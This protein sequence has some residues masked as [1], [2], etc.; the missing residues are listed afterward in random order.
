M[1]DRELDFLSFGEVLVDFFP[2][3]PGRPLS[4]VPRFTRHVGGA[5]ANVAVALARLGRRSGMHTLVGR[6]DFGVFLRSAL[7]GEGVDV[8]GV[9]THPSARTG[10]TF[11]S[12]GPKGERS[13]LFYRH[14]SA[15]QMI[16]PTDVD[17]A[18]IGK[19]R[20]FHFGSST[21]S[22]EPARSA[23]LA[24][25]DAARAAGCVV[26]C[27][28]NVR[29]HLWEE[30]GAPR[31]WLEHVMPQVHVLKVAEDELLATC[32]MSDPARAAALLRD[33]GAQ[34][35]VVTRADKG[36]IYDGAEAGTGSVACASVPVVDTTGAGDGFVAG[37]WTA[38][39]E[40]GSLALT[41][42]AVDAACLFGHRV[43][44]RVVGAL[45]ATAAL[46]RRAGLVP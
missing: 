10:I 46:P 22:R 13:F 35:V 19:A 8:R 4:E 32:A 33:W 37:F 44:A 40:L 18:L 29:P 3:E 31:R 39:F 2:D 26:S 12:V 24:A 1:S 6:D 23:T 43:A 16:S 38:L 45:G 5:P 9:G 7:S 11:V 27:D 42:D 15:D 34:L 17:E 41:R 36:C 28:S 21:L 25:V 30:K 20:V 14:P